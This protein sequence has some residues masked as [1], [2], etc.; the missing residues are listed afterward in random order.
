MD[1][2]LAIEKVQ[3]YLGITKAQYNSPIARDVQPDKLLSAQPNVVLI[4]MESM[5]AA[6]MKRHGSAE[7]LTPFLDSLSNNSIYFENIYT[8]GKHTFNGIF[9]TLFSF[10]ALYRQHSMKTNNQ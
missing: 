1:D 2:K 5:S 4:I 9:S 7:E 8:T 10:P 6:K 3:K